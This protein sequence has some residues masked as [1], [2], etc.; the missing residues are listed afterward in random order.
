MENGDTPSLVF[1]VAF[2]DTEQFGSAVT[3]GVSAAVAKT[4][5]YDG[6]ER[7]WSDVR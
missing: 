4:A 2:R 1:V 7:P 6:H 5:L 3:V